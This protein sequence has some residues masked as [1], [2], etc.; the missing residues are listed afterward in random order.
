LEKAEKK[1]RAK[2]KKEGSGYGKSRKEE[3]VCCSTVVVVDDDVVVS[4]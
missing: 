3:R 1:G 4:V 2:R